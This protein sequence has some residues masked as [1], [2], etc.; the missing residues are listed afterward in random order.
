MVGHTKLGTRWFVV[1]AVTQGPRSR[2]MMKLKMKRCDSVTPRSPEP[3]ETPTE[4]YLRT[5][6]YGTSTRGPARGTSVVGCACLRGSPPPWCAPPLTEPDGSGWSCRYHSQSS[7]PVRLS[8]V[9]FAHV[10]RHHRACQ[11]HA[12][13][14]DTHSPFTS[15]RA[16]EFAHSR[17]H[18]HACAHRCRRRPTCA[19]GVRAT[20]SRC[21]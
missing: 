8:P 14:H 17:T 18:A 1:G 16:R 9:P 19:R 12:H 10:A 21:A 13:A 7:E 20:A 3:D 5:Q 4:R 11:Q 6:L 15:P 2:S